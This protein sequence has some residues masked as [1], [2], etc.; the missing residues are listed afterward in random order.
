MVATLNQEQLDNYQENGY[1][2]LRSVF[3]EDE[4]NACQAECSRLLKLG[5]KGIARLLLPRALQL[6]LAGWWRGRVSTAS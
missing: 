2:I 4:I 6:R 5:I 1:L 3:S